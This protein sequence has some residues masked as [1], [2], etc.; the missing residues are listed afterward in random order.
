MGI[1]RD[2]IQFGKQCAEYSVQI[3]KGKDPA[4]LPMDVGKKFS[5][6][7]NIKAASIVGYNPSIDILSAADEIYKEIETK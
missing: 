3:L 1:G 4:T 6:L 2:K 7:L 5:I